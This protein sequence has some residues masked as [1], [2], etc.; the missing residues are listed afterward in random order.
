MYG[1]SAYSYANDPDFTDVSRSEKFWQ[2]VI[3]RF[4]EKYSGFY[5]WHQRIVQEAMTTGQLIMPTGRIYT[6]GPK[7][8]FRGDL[9]AP[10]TISKN[11][12]VNFSG[13]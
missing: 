2:K 7:R 3:D 5:R 8:N 13:L 1:G 4:Y 11:Y 6:Y 10:E 9:E 12:P